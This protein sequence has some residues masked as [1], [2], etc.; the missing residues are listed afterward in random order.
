[1]FWG[2]GFDVT[3]TDLASAM[4]EVMLDSIELQPGEKASLS[5][6]LPANFVIVMEPVTHAAHFLDVKGEPTRERQNLSIIYNTVVAPTRN[7][8]RRTR[9][10]A[11]VVRESYEAARASERVG[12]RR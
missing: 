11:L 7:D 8:A 3:D 2:S 10:V 9:T 4:R 12:R 1:M 5:L 6:A